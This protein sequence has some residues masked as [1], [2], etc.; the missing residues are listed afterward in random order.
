M[1]G[2]GVP[3]SSSLDIK[4]ANRNRACGGRAIRA[5]L[6][7]EAGKEKYVYKRL[8]C[9]RWSC[10]E[11]GPR[12]AWQL[13]KD[14]ESA[15][16]EK[17]LDRFLTLTLNPET[18]PDK[19]HPY[20][21]IWNVWGKFRVYLGRKYK[22]PISYICVLELHESVLPLHRALRLDRSDQQ[23]FIM[24]CTLS[25][26][27]GTYFAHLVEPQKRENTS[28]AETWLGVSAVSKVFS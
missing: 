23:E 26:K 10:P 27:Q 13:S 1:G 7:A 21:H 28:D 4:R 12:M 24:D 3:R 22:E 18:I 19:D 9:K 6:Q 20:R 25:T 11:C 17:G 2:G 14:I 5:E 15:A 16:G 8:Y